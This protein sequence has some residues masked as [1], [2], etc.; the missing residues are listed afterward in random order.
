MITQAQTRTPEDINPQYAM[1]ADVWVEILG[2][3]MH[4][5][6]WAGGDNASMEAATNRL[7]DM[8]IE[9]LSVLP[10]Q[11]VLDVG[12]GN[13]APAVRVAQATKADV[14]SIDI[15][16]H[17]LHLAK[18]RV[19]AE[20]L[21][22]R[23]TVQHAEVDDMPFANESFDA[24]WSS[25]CLMHVPDWT[26]SLRHIARVLRPG[27]RLVITDC[28]ERAP[29]DSETRAFLDD[30]YATMHCRYNKLDEIPQLVRDAG[31]ELVELTEIGEHILKRTM[32]AVDHGLRER[33]KDIEA[34]RGMPAE[35]TDKIGKQG[36]RFSELPEAGYA[37]MVARKPLV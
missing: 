37:V 36:V 23:I 7:T 31:L 12:C 9:R 18:E 6:Y 32:K 25:E 11:R 30:Y 21:E 22:Y 4:A 1:L 17:Q 13:G 27:G 2:G 3:N 28:V 20:R 15:G 19:I 14:V 33:A 34:K 35:I 26:E 24:A 16:P 5:G 29:V 10:G 8:V